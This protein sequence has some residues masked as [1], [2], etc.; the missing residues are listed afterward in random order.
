[1]KPAVPGGARGFT[2]FE[3]L[4]TV[5]V[6]GVLVTALLHYLARYQDIARTAV[7]EMTVV[8]MRS[9][10][11]LRVAEL[12]IADRNAEIG[13]LVHENPIGWL[14]VTDLCNLH[15][16]GCYRLTLNIHES[17]DVVQEE[18]YLGGTQRQDYF[19][20]LIGYLIC[21]EDQ[22]LVSLGPKTAPEDS[23]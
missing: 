19:K 2:R 14:E 10:L 4:G 21:S 20:W 17:F 6:I 1:M 7:M 15:C 12:M 9:G 18:A 16:R 13:A 22:I 3:W 23:Q 8:N 11:R 5:L